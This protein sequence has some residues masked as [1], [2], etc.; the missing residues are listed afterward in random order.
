[1]P[2]AVSLRISGRQKWSSR[3]LWLNGCDRL[4]SSP[5]WN[6]TSRNGGWL[7]GGLEVAR[8]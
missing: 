8:A 6:T 3:E 7:Y 5:F 4:L 1:M 2:H